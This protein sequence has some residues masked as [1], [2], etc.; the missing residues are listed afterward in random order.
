MATLTLRLPD[1]KHLRLKALAK[2]RHIS[3]NKLMEELSTQAI[4]EF[5][6]ETRF[7]AMASKGSIKKGLE[8]LD[9]LDKT[10]QG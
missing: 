1:D 4:A 9:H 5:D 10:F 8:V 6:A 7:R 2:K 3:V